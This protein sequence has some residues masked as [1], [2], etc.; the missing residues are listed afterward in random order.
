MD[1]FEYCSGNLF[2]EDVPMADLAARFGTP[3]Y[4]YSADTLL[5]HYRK[6]VTAFAPLNPLICYA[7][8]ACSNIHLC[9][10]L[11]KAGSG[12]DVVSG[13]ELYRALQAGADPAKVV[14][15]GVGKT[16]PE[17]REALA[18]G[19]G[20]FNAESISELTQIA[21]LAREMGKTARVAL[22]VNPDVDAKTHAYTTT[23]KKEN[24]FGVDIADAPAVF[25]KFRGVGGLSLHAIHLHIGSPV[26]DVTSYTRSIERGLQLIDAL[27][28]AGHAID[29]IDIGGGFG[30]YYKGDEAPPTAD[31]AAAIVPLLKDRKLNVVIEPGR[32]LVANAGVLLT[33]VIHLKPGPSKQFVIVDASMNELIRP[34]LYGA[35][36]FIWPVAAGQ[37]VPGSRGPEQPFDGLQKCDVVGPVCE[38][39]DFLAK[40]RMLPSVQQGDLIAVYSAGAYAMAMASQYNSRPRAAEVLVEG[41]SA[42]LI[43]RRETYAD[44]IAAELEPLPG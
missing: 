15:A 13:G 9:K 19:I 43:R 5:T 3:L 6:L 29:T 34:A 1:R 23:G 28:A 40:D 25:E 2:V 31:Y 10:L 26:N 24:K 38:S 16:S 37:R 12:F 30:A 32:S 14:F 4:V 35:Y 7:V 36:H 33:R 41:A 44:L 18:A 17:I 39:S 27:R 8:K 42:R 20:G 21:S 11:A 22:R